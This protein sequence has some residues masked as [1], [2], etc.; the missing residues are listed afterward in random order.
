[1]L[2]YYP[3]NTQVTIYFKHEMNDQINQQ[4]VTLSKTYADVPANLDGF[5]QTGYS[6]NL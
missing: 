6:T 4:V 2:L 1:V 3:K 5:M